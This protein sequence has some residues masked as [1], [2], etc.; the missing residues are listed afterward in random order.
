MTVMVVTV[1]NLIRVAV[2]LQNVVMDTAMVMKPKNH[3]QM[4]VVEVAL[5]TVMTVNLI[6]LRTD[7]NAAIQLGMSLAL[8][9]LT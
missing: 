8:A 9:V 7:L 1:R 5:K 2:E 6:S 3:V 4:I